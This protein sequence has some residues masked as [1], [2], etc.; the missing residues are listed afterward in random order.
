VPLEFLGAVCFSTP[1]GTHPI[2]ITDSPTLAGCGYGPIAVREILLT[3]GA[4]VKG[5]GSRKVGRS[6]Y[7]SI[8]RAVVVNDRAKMLIGLCGGEKVHVEFYLH[9]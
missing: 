1:R 2:S 7:A 4:I 9:A 5:D 3:T 6:L 8:S